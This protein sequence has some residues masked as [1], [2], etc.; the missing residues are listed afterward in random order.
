M[1]WRAGPR[2]RGESSTGAPDATPEESGTHARGGYLT[3]RHPTRCGWRLPTR[4]TRTPFPEDDGAGRVPRRTSADGPTVDNAD[5]DGRPLSLFPSRVPRNARR[6]SS[7]TARTDPPPRQTRPPPP[8]EGPPAAT[9][10]DASGDAPETT[11]RR[12]SKGRARERGHEPATPEPDSPAPRRV[13]SPLPPDRGNAAGVRGSEATSTR[14]AVTS[15]TRTRRARR[16]RGRGN[17][18]DGEGRE[19]PLAA[20]TD[21]GRVGPGSPPPPSPAIP[22]APHPEA[23]APPSGS[24]WGGTRVPAALG[25]ARKRGPLRSFPNH[26]RNNIP[27]SGTATPASRHAL[28]CPAWFLPGLG[29]RRR[30]PQRAQN[31]LGFPPPKSGRGEGNPAKATRIGRS[32]GGLGRPRRVQRERPQARPFHRIAR[33]GTFLTEGGRDGPGP[34]SPRPRQQTKS[35]DEYRSMISSVARRGSLRYR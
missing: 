1:L 11:D 20:G 28:F 6:A 5:D 15:D 16:G 17:G 12:F 4:E 21:G 25:R 2:G 26:G 10:P 3:V 23:C 35:G 13:G 19:G 7:S 18:R 24:V 8:K 32:Q 30:G 22:C 31:T 14:H 29:A 27:G 33:E 9:G 34:T